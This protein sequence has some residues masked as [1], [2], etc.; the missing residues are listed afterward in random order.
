[1]SGPSP[2]SLELLCLHFP[3]LRLLLPRRHLPRRRHQHVLPSL[4]LI[5]AERR[6]RQLHLRVLQDQSSIKR[7]VSCAEGII[8]AHP[9]VQMGFPF[10][11]EQGDEFAGIGGREE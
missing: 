3:P 8:R 5:P 4:P 7:L 11:V 10:L 6:S 9:S 2:P 1:M